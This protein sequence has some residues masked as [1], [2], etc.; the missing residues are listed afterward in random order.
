MIKPSGVFI[1]SAI[2][3]PVFTGFVYAEDPL[4]E[5]LAEKKQ[6]AQRRIYSEQIIIED[7][8]L[9]LP[10]TISEEEKE[11]DRKID[12][13][14]AKADAEA[15]LKN[16]SQLP[17]STIITPLPVQTNK[18]WLIDAL[19]EKTP[20]TPIANPADDW[21][22]QETERQEAL[23]TAAKEKESV[24]K[25]L[26]EQSQIHKK[27][28]ES[29]NKTLT[30][31]GLLQQ[32]QKNQQEALYTL[33]KNEFSDTTASSLIMPKKEATSSVR[34]F[35]L[36][37]TQQQTALT[38]PVKNPLNPAAQPS[39][40]PLSANT[41]SDFD[42]FAPVSLTPLQ[43]IKQ[44]SPIYRTDPFRNDPLSVGKTSIWD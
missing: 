6:K 13:M 26:K 44:S 14:N 2:F 20:T 39:A 29:K 1:L 43:Q 32:R 24:E 5:A 11:L 42:P 30:S 36:P 38:P 25:L 16:R 18:N 35:S 12:E 7:A 41:D 21:L 37:A 34:P 40:G 4:D 15:S 9:N 3:L 10:K 31:T 17:Q 28:D 22:K 27:E 19:S 33:P 23:Q 8:T